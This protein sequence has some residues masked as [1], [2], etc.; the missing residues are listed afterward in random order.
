MGLKRLSNLSKTRFL[1]KYCRILASE[2]NI[3]TLK[4]APFEI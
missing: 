2:S 3:L 4:V 1:V